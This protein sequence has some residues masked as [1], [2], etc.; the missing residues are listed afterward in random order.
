LTKKETFRQRDARAVAFGKLGL[1]RIASYIVPDNI[2]S[3]R[4]AE[5]IGASEVKQFVKDGP[6]YALDSREAQPACDRTDAGHA[7]RWTDTV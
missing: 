4:V 5:K 7:Y 6:V 3:R 2:A 1:Q